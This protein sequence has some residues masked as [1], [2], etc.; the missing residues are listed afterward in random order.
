MKKIIVSLLLIFATFSFTIAQTAATSTTKQDKAAIAAQKKADKEAKAEAKKQA[1]EAKV[2]AKEQA[3]QANTAASNTAGTRM[4][5]NGTPDKRFKA[6]KQ[7]KATTQAPPVQVQNPA[8]LPS[9][10]QTAPTPRNS[11]TTASAREPKVKSP[12]A[13]IGTDAKGRTLYQGPKG[14]KYYLTKNGN[15]EYEK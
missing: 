3:Q 1:K 5:K 14:G 15:K 6:N 2:Q 7:P 9:A 8:P 13:V 10:T 11:K 4:N 12:D